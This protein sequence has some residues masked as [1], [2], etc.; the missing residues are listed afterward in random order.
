M[1]NLCNPGRRRWLH[2]SACAVASASIGGAFARTQSDNSTAADTLN[3]FHRRTPVTASQIKHL[4]SEPT[5]HHFTDHALGAGVSLA[6]VHTDKAAARA[7][8]NLAFAEMK[9]LERVFSLY[10]SDSSLVKL[11]TAGTLELPPAELLSVFHTQ[12]ACGVQPT[13]HLTQPY[14]RTGINDTQ[15]HPSDQPSVGV[16][17]AIAQAE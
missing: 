2:I 8:A 14:N 12:A 13:E 7:L 9:R 6:I 4:D 5:T 10:L 15:R 16:M 1:P 17:C 3:T 11:N